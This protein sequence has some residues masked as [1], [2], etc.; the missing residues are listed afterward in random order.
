MS[1]EA[2]TCNHD[3]FSAESSAVQFS[4]SAVSSRI[5]ERVFYCIQLMTP[6]QE[7]IIT[8]VDLQLVGAHQ[9]Y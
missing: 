1:C 8:V 5:S 7:M 2:R 9:V 6:T 4:G 3:V